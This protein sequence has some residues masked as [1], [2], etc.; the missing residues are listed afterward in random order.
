MTEPIHVNPLGPAA[1]LS[2]EPSLGVLGV[3]AGDVV[4]VVAQYLES[5]GIQV[6]FGARDLE[7]AK[8]HA[9]TLLSVIGVQPTNALEPDVIH[10]SQ[11][12]RR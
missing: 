9:L 1:D 5:A 8:T 7:A 2:P 11:P 4:A 6:N 3:E 12:D 10:T